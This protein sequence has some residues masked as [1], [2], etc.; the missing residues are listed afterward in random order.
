MRSLLLWL[1]PRGLDALMHMAMPKEIRDYFDFTEKLARTRV[2]DERRLDLEKRPVAREDMF[3]FLCTARNPD[4]DDFA[5][6]TED[7]I[8]DA[9][10][11]IVAG[12]DTS[13]TTVTGL[14]F[15]ITR[16][17]RV[18]AKLVEEI[19]DNFETADEIGAGQDFMAKCEYLRAVIHETMRLCPPGPSEVERT[20]LK[21]GTIIAGERVAEGVTLGV[22]MWALSQNEEVWGDASTFRPER[23]VVSDHPDTFNSLEEVNRLKR[24]YHPFSKGVGACLGQK[25]AMIQICIIVARTLWRYDVKNA[26]GQRV[27]E[28]KPELGWGRSNR[29]HFQ[30]RDAYIGLREG[31][32]VQFRKRETD[33]A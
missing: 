32:I 33:R 26:E 4:T 21:G 20:V 6:T 7:L 11:L 22:P 8:A 16:H 25:M 14:F 10:L 18:Y 23:W 31:P 29:N 15:Y 2:E 19:R 1:K 30:F 5:L 3:H 13:S 28:G 27:G 9:N 17:P 12:S 24:S